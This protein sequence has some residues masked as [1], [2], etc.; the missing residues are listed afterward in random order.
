MR[1]WTERAATDAPFR[2]QDIKRAAKVLSLVLAREALLRVRSQSA[3]RVRTTHVDRQRV[4]RPLAPQGG[5]ASPL[6]AQDS[7]RTRS[8]SAAATAPALRLAP[9]WK[10]RRAQTQNATRRVRVTEVSARA[11]AFARR[12]FGRRASVWGTVYDART[13]RRTTRLYGLLQRARAH[14]RGRQCS[15][16]PAELG[17]TTSS[18]TSGNGPCRT[19]ALCVRSNAS[20]PA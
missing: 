20:M 3:L 9:A 6:P 4:C 17:V 5:S 8:R 1:T 7:N 15:E 16:G 11:D 10:T 18:G 12:G 2:V 13:T 19:S 14:S